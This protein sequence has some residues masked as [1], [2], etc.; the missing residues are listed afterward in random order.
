[1]NITFSTSQS[2]RDGEGCVLTKLCT[3][4]YLVALA[5]EKPAQLG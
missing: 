2:V 5:C 1:M 4:P 3:I